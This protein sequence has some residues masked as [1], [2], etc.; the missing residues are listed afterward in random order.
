VDGAI[1][2][3]HSRSLPV[4]PPL[5]RPSL[6]GRPMDVAR[7]PPRRYGRLIGATLG[8]AVLVGGLSTLWRSSSAAAAPRVDRGTVWIE[9]V[10]RGTLLRQVAAQGTLV[11][12]HV[13]WLSAP[14][15]GRVAHIYLRAGAP[16]Q[17]DTVVLALENPDLELATLEAEHQAASA[18]A[19]LIQLDVRTEADRKMAHSNLVDLRAQLQA[20]DLHATAADALAGEGLM[21]ELD[22]GDALSKAAG[23]HD[24]VETE[25][26]REQLLG[27][28][29]ERQLAAQRT[30]V[31]RLREIAKFRHH[32]LDMLQI[33]AGIDGVVEDVP[34]ENGQWVAIGTTLAK[35]AEPEKLQAEVRVAENDAKQ[36]H[37]GLPVRFEVPAGG[38]RGHVDR[39]D[40]TVVSG[41]VRLRVALD[42]ALPAGARADQTVSGYVEIESL[43]DVLS[44]ARPAGAAEGATLGLYRLEADGVHAARVTVRLGRGSAREV[45]VL[46]GL[47]E[48]DKLVVSDTSS[49]DAERVALK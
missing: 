23:L 19:A 41:S 9:P 21:G 45:E 30:E 15:A 5:A 34:L 2:F 1:F 10:R 14:S 27:D 48:G 29:R 40:P 13:Q 24:R 32:Q 6:K 36:V 44:V 12:E 47:N 39:V 28:G 42:G 7:K 20:A 35:V 16:V 43:P 4:I 31:A 33:K 3:F 26:A 11:P 18:E 38:L 22:H 25:Q 8:A 49:W 17:A 37:K 46:G